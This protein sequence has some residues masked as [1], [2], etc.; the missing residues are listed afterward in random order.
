M[1]LFEKDGTR[2]IKMTERKMFEQYKMSGLVSLGK[3]F[4]Q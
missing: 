3:L 1:P 4:L 2:T